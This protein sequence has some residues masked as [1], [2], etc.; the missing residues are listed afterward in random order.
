MKVYT[1][2]NQNSHIDFDPNSGPWFGYGANLGVWGKNYNPMNNAN[3]GVCY[4]G[5]DPY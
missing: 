1:P 2:K 3:E 4:S 5:Y